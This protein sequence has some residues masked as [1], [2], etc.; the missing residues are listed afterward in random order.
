M[1]AYTLQVVAQRHAHPTPAAIIMSLESAFAALGGWLMLN[2]R[3]DNRGILGAALMMAGMVLAQL[4]TAEEAPLDEVP[5][6][7][8][9]A[10]AD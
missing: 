10:T 8:G 2:E 4:K 6:A 9:V 3:L 1:I 5:A 7:P